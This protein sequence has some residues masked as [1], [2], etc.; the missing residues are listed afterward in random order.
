[1]KPERWRQVDELF[2][3]AKEC[4]GAERAAFLREASAGDEAL[5][6]EVE[7]LLAAHEQEG[8][9]IDSPAYADTL[10]VDNQ[11]ELSAGQ[12][13][14]SY[15]VMSR[16]GRGGMG[17]VY[18]AA[19]ADEQF[20]KRVAIKLLKAGFDH[21]SIIRR[22]RNE[23]QILASLDHPNIARLVDGGTTTDGSPYFV[24][25]YV[26]G[27]SISDYCDSRRL[28]TAERLKLFRSV[29]SAVHYAHQNLIVHRDIKPGNILVT[30]DGT[31]KLLD[32]GIAK[33]LG[34]SAILGEMTLATARVM[35]PEYAS[36]EQTRGEAITT[37]SDVYSL[38]VLLYELLTGR[39]PYRVT[40]ASPLEIIQAICEQDPE[41]PSTAIGRT[42]TTTGAD[43]VS[44]TTV[45]A[46]SKARGSEP[47]KLRR[48][49]EGDLD[50][51]VLKA[52]RKEPQRRYSSVE[53]FSEDIRRYL[54]GLPISARKDTFTYRAGKFVRR[55]KAGVAAAAIIFILLVSGAVGIARQTIVANRQRAR[56]EKRFNEVRKLASSFMFKFHDSI[57]N[58]A[59]S[60]AA[61]KLVVSES[62]EYLNSL[63]DEA[64]D[65]P[66]FQ[67]ELA[68]A[69]KRLAEIQGSPGSANLG[70][71][72]GA[73]E[74]FKKAAAL[75]ESLV[76][77]G[78]ATVDDRLG[79]AR[80][81]AGLSDVLGDPANMEYARKAQ[82]IHEALLAADPS[83]HKLRGAAGVSY[84][85]VGQL[86]ASAR[87]LAG[88]LEN[89][90]K[91]LDIYKALSESDP[92]NQLHR[93][94]YALS[95]KSV[96]GTLILTGDLAAGEEN[97]RRALELEEALI[98]AD[99]NNAASR[100]DLSF[101]LSDLGWILRL[102][103][104]YAGA[105]QNYHRALA[106]R[107]ELSAADP[108]DVRVRLA[109]S[110]TYSKIGLI[111]K[112]TEDFA[113]AMEQYRKALEIRETMSAADPSNNE[114]K[115]KVADSHCWIAGVLGSSIERN[116]ASK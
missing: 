12:R 41:K 31:V 15:K 103:K 26:E 21:E 90:R 46:I 47:D 91:A 22:F 29:C 61:R 28:N 43:A 112:D 40:T 18:L 114:Y 1:M 83:N 104:D 30:A 10:L 115:Q 36:P 37:S 8:S 14:G 84:Y 105:L 64:S 74:S 109:L 24:M 23:R 88:A 20:H 13:L 57:E 9:F 44:T 51:I 60:T 82:E 85:T 54:E 108:K 11:A 110:T 48:Q 53:Q 33:L 16:I 99:P 69:Y 116:H 94:N 63:A 75:R 102:T 3:S 7:S 59:G 78:G 86:L 87:D 62:L 42:E 79:L 39:R 97:Y 34:P 100:L 17:A 80:T 66:E 55:N 19:R 71:T 113:G 68:E 107:E 6:R 111:L 38:G 106:I 58:L 45:E 96:G 95:C 73:A 81:Y 93:R 65:D 49:L 35:T 70:D 101:T 77:S 25:E 56:A 92:T 52:L 27:Q 4:E 32:F 2:H 76:A 89:F 5:R 50:N 72:A 98:A 67:R